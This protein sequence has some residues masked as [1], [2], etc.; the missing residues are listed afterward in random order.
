MFIK[1]TNGERLNLSWN[2][3]CIKKCQEYPGGIKKLEADMNDSRKSF[4][5][6]MFLIA[7]IIKSNYMNPISDDEALALIPLNEVD[8]IVSFIK[9]QINN[10]ESFKKKEMYHS[11]KKK[12]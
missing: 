3:L 9:K 8:N 7:V 11:Q 10:N 2:F 6:G 4:E 1:L 12:K 5:L